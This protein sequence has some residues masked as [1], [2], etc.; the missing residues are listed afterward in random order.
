[1]SS[2][3]N[4]G[5][6]EYRQPYD[7]RTGQ[8]VAGGPGA[9][10]P[11]PGRQYQ[12]FGAFSQP[13]Q[14]PPAY[15]NMPGGYPPPPTPPGKRRGPLIAAI[16]LAA[17]AVIAIVTTVVVLSASGGDQA[18]P[19]APPTS[20][21]TPTQPTSSAT[22]PTSVANPNLTPVVAGWQVVTV[23]KRGAVYDVP[24]GWELDPNPDNIHGIGPPDDPVT[25]TGVAD[26][27]LGFCPGDANSYRATSGATARKGP[28]DTAVASET[29]QKFATLAYTR[30]G[31]APMIVP[32]PVEQLRLAGGT[33]P[34]VRVTALVTL[35]TPGP[36]DAASVAVSVLATNSDGESSVVFIAAADQ[37]VPDAVSVDTLKQIT[38]TFR[39]APN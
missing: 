36:C 5:S 23:P 27:Q 4:W 14:P 17:V 16:A 2:P 35:P 38:E 22:S 1:M 31:Q 21:S 18:A 30:D 8:P 10:G 20:T 28:D 3:G 39:G 32:G 12:G 33:T 26:Y 37:N 19:T 13:Q 25:M 9:S 24:P 15:P 34:A 11:Q 6:S 29:L 7:P